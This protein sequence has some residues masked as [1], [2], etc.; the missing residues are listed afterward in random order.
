MQSMK[1]VL[2]GTTFGVVGGGQ[3]G[4]MILR[5]AQR[6]GYRTCVW[7][8]SSD[9]PAGRLADIRII[10]PY[11]EPT[12]LST[13]A[14]SVYAATYEF[15]NIDAAP[16]QT[17]ESKIPFAPD[18]KL[19]SIAQHRS[20]E[21]NELRKGG[22]PTVKFAEAD[23]AQG[24]RDAVTSIGLPVVIKTA[25]SGYDGKGQT[26]VKSSDDLENFLRLQSPLERSEIRP[27]V[28]TDSEHRPGLVEPSGKPRLYPSQKIHYVIE[29]LVDLACE[30][31]VIVVRGR[32]GEIVTYPVG[33]NEHCEN[34]LH[35]TRVPARVSESLQKQAIELGKSVAEHF[36]LV[37]LL[38][39][40]MFVTKS[41]E[42]LVN[43]LAPRPHNS[44]H[45]SLDACT[46]SQFESVIR[47]VCGL[48]IA[49]PHLLTPCAMINILGKHLQR[50]DEKNMQGL[51]R[52]DGVK[53]H[54]Y[55]K[56]RLEPKRK[57]GHITVLGP[58]PELVESQLKKIEEIIGG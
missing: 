1:P 35:I 4:M 34:I 30:V 45:Y 47:A 50:L 49:A 8:P 18:S 14:S 36:G 7:D 38:C 21:K 19:L 20:T 40:E 9:C 29:Q 11:N 27:A 17:L 43:E 56:T 46:V 55:G 53:L 51:L 6:M 33:E 54:L 52:L 22:F 2:P 39:V 41:G 28:G 10:A 48:P 25:T 32:D 26:V 44:G 37:G 31:S 13:F 12:A 3:L 24:I 23:S 5:E 42:L 16:I 15:E 57:M 58:T